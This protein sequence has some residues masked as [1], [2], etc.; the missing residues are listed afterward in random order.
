LGIVCP[1]FFALLPA[2]WT[3]FDCI[4]K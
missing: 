3:N 2:N 4:Q 1:N